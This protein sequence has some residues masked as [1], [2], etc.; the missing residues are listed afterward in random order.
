MG[1]QARVAEAR[2]VL[3]RRL[4]ILRRDAGVHP[5]ADQ[6]KGQWG[7]GNFDMALVVFGG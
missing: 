5:G 7:T 3:A 4:A 6:A 1:A 2:L